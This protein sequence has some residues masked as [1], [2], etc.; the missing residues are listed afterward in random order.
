MVVAGPLITA[1]SA[2]SSCR[3]SGRIGIPREGVR[4]DEAGIKGGGIPISIAPWTTDDAGRIERKSGDP[5]GAYG[6]TLSILSWSTGKN[7]AGIDL[8]RD[9]LMPA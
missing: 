7:E 8:C 5:A 2:R 6:D 1:F 9:G 3:R 4:H